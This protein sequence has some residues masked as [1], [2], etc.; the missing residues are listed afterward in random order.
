MSDAPTVAE[1]CAELGQVSVATGRVVF[2]MLDRDLQ[3]TTSEEVKHHLSLLALILAGAKLEAAI[4]AQ[5][6][7]RS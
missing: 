1:L 3:R 2:D 7:A 5:Q 6:K 4:A